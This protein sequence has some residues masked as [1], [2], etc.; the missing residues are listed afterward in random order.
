MVCVA[1]GDAKK[2]G[3]SLALNGSLGGRFGLILGSLFQAEGGE[4]VG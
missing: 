4:T 2:A 1:G 3:V